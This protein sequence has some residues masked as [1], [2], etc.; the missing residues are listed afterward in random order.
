M[1]VEDNSISRVGT[2]EVDLDYIKSVD[3]RKKFSK[4]TSNSK[5]NDAIRNQSTSILTKFKGTDTERMVIVDGETGKIIFDKIGLKDALGVFLNEDEVSFVKKYKGKKIAIHNHP[6]N[7]LP[8][9]SDF[10]SAGYREYDFGLVLTHDGKVFKYAPGNI[11]FTAGAFDKR[12]DKYK[13]IPYNLNEIEAHKK[14][15]NEFRE[16]YGITWE[17]LN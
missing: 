4:L 7:I 11:P 3:Y 17:E 15:L 10:V 16:E 8:T 12:I 5:V 2:N 13:G 14:V 9:G 1:S 6:T